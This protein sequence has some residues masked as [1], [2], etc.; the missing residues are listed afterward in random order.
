VKLAFQVTA[1][2]HPV[3][4]ASTDT[5]ASNNGASAS[6]GRSLLR[7]VVLWPAKALGLKLRIA[8]SAL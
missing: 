1:R 7:R 4:E 6:A 8:D 3:S 5:P 2:E